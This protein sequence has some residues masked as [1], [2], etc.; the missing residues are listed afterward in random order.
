M[1]QFPEYHGIT[2]AAGG[3]IENVQIEKLTSDPVPVSAGRIWYN[4][5]E[6]HFKYSS[7]DNTGAI[8]IATFASLDDLNAA[9]TT[10]N[11]SVS[12]EV[13]RATAAEATLTSDL[14]SE[15]SRAEAAE[16]A[17]TSNLTA[18]IARAEAAEGVLTT[19]LAT[20]ASARAAADQALGLRIDALGNVFSYVATIAGGA[21]SSTA[22]DVATL[23]LKNAGDYYKVSATGWF[24]QGAGT[25]FQAF[26]GDGLVFNLSGAIDI[27]GNLDSQVNGTTDFISVT[28]T[29]V[30]GFVIDV[31]ATFKGRVST[32]ESGLT[33]EIARATA[34]EGVLTTA[35]AAEATRATGAEAAIQSELDA[36]QAGA[37]LNTDGTYAANGSANYIASASSLADADTKLDTALKAVSTALSNE[38]SRASDAES[39]LTTNLSNE[40]ARATSAETVLTNALSSEVSR[41]TTAETTLQ[42]NIDALASSGGSALT[43]E[44]ARATAAEGVLTSNLSS[45]VSRA[46]AAETTLTNNLSDEVTRATTAETSLFNALDS[47]TSRATAAETTLTNNLSSE[48]SRATAAESQ[49]RSDYNATQFTF[50]SSAPALTHVISHNLGETFV[51]FTVLVQRDSG[52]FRNDV[53]SVE[54]TNSN[55]LTVYLTTARNIKVA[56]KSF[57]AL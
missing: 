15:V 16:S 45:E 27:I 54:E 31:D 41:A 55:T 37:G 21:D 56:V 36:T 32:L 5:T 8:V 43:A 38:V 53:V 35:V 51:D 30:T 10:L 23:E 22:F 48:V 39:T 44:I 3:W 50:A 1:S 24:V 6:T 28:G 46:T 25:P 57:A 26:I 7:L 42:S 17:L 4:V 2:L 47:E 12:N 18:E 11:T 29:P 9:V 19:N 13:S 52:L 20:E 40:V 33:S 34:A 14:A 49:I